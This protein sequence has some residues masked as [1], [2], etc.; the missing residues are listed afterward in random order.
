[1]PDFTFVEK[2]PMEGHEHAL[3]A[4]AVVGREG[5]EVV[6]PDPEVSRRHAALRKTLKAPRQ[7]TLHHS[8]LLGRPQPL[9]YQF[10]K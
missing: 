4:D 1:M 6:L 3:D 10:P 5:C 9:K 8:L 7:T 2:R